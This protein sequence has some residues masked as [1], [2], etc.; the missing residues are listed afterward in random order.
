[1][2]NTF[3][4][5]HMWLCPHMPGDPNLLYI[6]FDEPNSIS[7]IKFWNYSKT[8]SRGV[9]E[10]EVCLDPVG[11]NH[12]LKLYL[13]DN[14][15]YKGV[16]RKAPAQGTTMDFV[17]AI[18]FTTDDKV[19][20]REKEHVYSRVSMEQQVQFINDNKIVVPAKQPSSPRTPATTKRPSTSSGSV[21]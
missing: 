9:E 19:V 16:L 1:V 6:F 5:K 12:N 15:I 20:S 18:L 14:L 8:P 3:D 2:N 11:A 13:D 4:A 21:L 7:M 17:Q 10:F